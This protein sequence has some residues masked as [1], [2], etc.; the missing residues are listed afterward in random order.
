MPRVWT[1]ERHGTEEPVQPS[2]SLRV[3]AVGL[4]MLVLMLL[5]LVLMLLLQLLQQHLAGQVIIAISL[6]CRCMEI[7]VLLLL[8]ATVSMSLTA[9]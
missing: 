3:L 7:A 9:Q 1:V 2:S 4:L 6:T 5:M 8:Y